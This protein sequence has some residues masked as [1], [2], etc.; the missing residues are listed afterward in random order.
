M[1]E[2]RDQSGSQRLADLDSFMQS[3]APPEACPQVEILTLNGRTF[4]FVVALGNTNPTR[5]P[6]TLEAQYLALKWEEAGLDVIQ[7]TWAEAA[8]K[9]VCA[10]YSF[11]QDWLRE[12]ARKGNWQ[13]DPAIPL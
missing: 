12:E 5:K 4:N 7:D 9:P 8:L 6:A 2:V 3:A 10:Q 1:S 11:A 13:P